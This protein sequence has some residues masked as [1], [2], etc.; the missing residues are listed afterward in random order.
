MK[1]DVS[2]LAAEGWDFLFGQAA[3]VVLRMKP[4]GRILF[5]NRFAETLTGLALAGRS[6][7]D[8]I[9]SKNDPPDIGPW[10]QPSDEPLLANIRS[11]AGPPKTLSVRIVQAGDD[12][13]F[14]GEADAAEMERLCLEV[15]ALNQEHAGLS[16]ELGRA[17]GEL[18]RMM[19]ELEFAK[20]QAETATRAKSEFLSCMSHEIRTPMNGVIGM[21]G[22]LLGTPLTAEQQGY[23]ET[24]RSSGEALLDI[25][26]DI[27]DFAKIEAGKLQLELIPFDLHRVLED[28]IALLAIK[29]HEKSLELLFWYPADA[30]RDFLG[31]PGRIRQIALNLVSNAIKFTSHGHVLL[32][33]TC[34]PNA[35]HIRIAV[36]DT[37][38]GIAAEHIGRLFQQFQQVDAS[39]TRR[40]GGTGLGLAVC[41][42]L[43]ELM[44]GTIGVESRPGQGSSFHVDIALARAPSACTQAVPAVDLESIRVLVVDDHPICRSLTVALCSRWGMRVEQAS[45]GPEAL[46]RIEAADDSGEPFRIVCLDYMMPDMDGIT[47]ARNL[48]QLDLHKEPAIILITSTSERNDVRRIG[49]AGC[50][51]CL[52]KP[53]RESVL[54]DGIQR[55]L[56]GREP[57]SQSP[58]IPSFSSSVPATLPSVQTSQ[59]KGRRV[60]LVEDNAV[61]QKVGAALLAKLGCRTDIAGDGREA[62]RMATRLPY[63][64]I[65]MDC[66]M[67]QMDGYEATRQLRIHEGA[68]RRTPIVAMTANVL[69][70]DRERC[71]ASGMDDFISKPVNASRLRDVLEKHLVNAGT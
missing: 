59:I 13:L 7:A 18:A 8:I 69:T 15:L 63:D 2:D 54:L 12:L 10:L 71:F 22:L 32:E 49:D 39:T 57:G 16:R 50:H 61:N 1:S 20:E 48:R 9:Y 62:L 23:A 19:R 40:Y 68:A 52:V 33:V 31:D 56:A 21:T 35:S 36:R 65:L 34:D 26:N 58:G 5:S 38:I 4:D 25:I 42:K 29:A 3:V 67:P 11:A 37:G 27:L 44:G 60:L 51:L 17:N 64:L 70:E 28:V 55:A 45:S 66:Q 6:L 30:P 24:V 43:A 47:T 41:K 46:Q 53:L 14:F